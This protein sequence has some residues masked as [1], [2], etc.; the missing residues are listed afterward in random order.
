VKVVTGN[1][2]GSGLTDIALVGG[3]GWNTVPI[4]FATTGGSW[5]ITNMNA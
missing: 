5:T 3:P 1:F 4:A 2:S